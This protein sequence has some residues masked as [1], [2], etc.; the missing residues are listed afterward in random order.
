MER[1]HLEIQQESAE[2]RR[3]QGVE[4]IRKSGNLERL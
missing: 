4:E 2:N 1:T 3:K